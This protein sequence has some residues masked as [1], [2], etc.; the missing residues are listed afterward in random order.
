MTF[1]WR[2][3]HDDVMLLVESVSRE[4]LEEQLEG[5]KST[6]NEC[7]GRCRAGGAAQRAHGRASRSVLSTPVTSLSLS[8]YRVTAGQSVRQSLGDLL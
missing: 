8:S 7:Q 5:R 4:R 3:Q 2:I 6:I 1:E